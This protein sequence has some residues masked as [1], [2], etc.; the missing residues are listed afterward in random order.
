MRDNNDEACSLG[1]ALVLVVTA[2]AVLVQLKGSQ[3]WIPK[4]V[5][6]EDSDVTEDADKGDEGE[7][8]VK[9]WFAEKEGLV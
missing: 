1:K 3:T 6:H 8:F 2:K 5:I 7:L 9:E 4:S